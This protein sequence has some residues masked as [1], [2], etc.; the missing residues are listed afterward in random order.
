MASGGGRTTKPLS[1]CI[2]GN[3]ENLQIET[4]DERNIAINTS[5]VETR[6][7]SELLR[8]INDAPIMTT[9]G[10]SYHLSPNIGNLIDVN[11]AFFEKLQLLADVLNRQPL[12]C[13]KLTM[14]GENEQFIEPRRVTRADAIK[15]IDR[16]RNEHPCLIIYISDKS[17]NSYNGQKYFLYQTYGFNYNEIVHDVRI[18]NNMVNLNAHISTPIMFNRL[19]IVDCPTPNVIQPLL[20]SYTPPPPPPP[21][22]NNSSSASGGGNTWFELNHGGKKKRTKRHRKNRRNTKRRR[23]R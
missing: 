2:F 12:P 16:N 20:Q 5:V 18:G 14:Y 7:N 13:I 19:T 8:R 15:I 4:K 9:V 22:T 1:E 11:E 17:I 6:K 21:R 23:H 3:L 10:T